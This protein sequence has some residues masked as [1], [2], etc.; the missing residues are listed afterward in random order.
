VTQRA[1][2]LLL[3]SVFLDAL[4]WMAVAAEPKIANFEN[5]AIKKELE[6]LEGTWTIVS[7]ETKA[8]K[9][10][11]ED[12]KEMQLTIKGNQWT[13][14]HS[15][16]SDKAT[17]KID[18]TKDPKTIDLVFSSLGAM[19]S[20][21]KLPVG[22]KIVSRGIYKLEYKQGEGY[23]LTLCRV[24]EQR[25]TRPKK[26]KTTESSGLLFVFKRKSE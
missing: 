22:R 19:G 14:T 25:A 2:Q 8:T 20:T 10:P 11:D 26:F 15:R 24:D 6:K 4:A 1:V 13:M 16:G 21:F 9:T 17:M 7:R 23:I 3:L 5:D 18:P 12:L